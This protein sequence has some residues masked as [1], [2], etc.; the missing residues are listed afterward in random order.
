MLQ[1][2]MARQE[3]HVELGFFAII[4]RQPLQEQIPPLR[5]G[6]ASHDGN[7]DT[8]FKRGDLPAGIFHLNSR[9]TNVEG[10]V[11]SHNELK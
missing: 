5:G 11:L 1:E 8:I 2:A 4:H 3:G 9:L 7:L 10:K 6:A